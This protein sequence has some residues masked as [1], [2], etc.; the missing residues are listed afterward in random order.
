MTASPQDHANISSQLNDSEV[1]ELLLTL[2]RKQGTWVD[3]GQACQKLQ[4]IGQSP[5]AIFEQTGFEPIQQNQI[6]VAVQV[7]STIVSA[8][9]STDAQSFFWQRGSDLLYE[10]RILNQTERATAAEL[11]WAKQLDA[12]AAKEVA[13]AVKDYSRLPTDPD[14][15]SDHPG[16]AVAY[17]YWRQIRQKSDL[18]ERSRLIA[19]AFTYVHSPAARQQIEKLLTD[20]SVTPTRQA[21][22]WPVYRLDTDENLPRMLPVVGQFPLTQADLQAVPLVE[23]VE[24]FHWVHF[25]GNCAWVALPGWQVIMSA[26]DPVAI[27]CNTDELPTPP[28]GAAERVLVIVDRAQR[29]WDVESYFLSEQAEHLS[30]QWF[31]EQPTQPLLGRIILVMRPRKILDE[32]YTKELWQIDE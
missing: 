9:L 27:L 23:S 31:E 32:D 28:P 11:I 24:P 21:P 26:E 19:K 7:Y 13:K 17:Q 12:D 10:L 3:W 25:S 16:D 30:F 20:F 4:K 18:Q 14:G 29:E 2:R 22:R 8:G 5:Q 1:A 6:T 15:F